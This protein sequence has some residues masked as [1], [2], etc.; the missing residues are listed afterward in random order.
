MRAERIRTDRFDLEPLRVEHAAEMAPLLADEALHR[1]TGGRPDSPAELRARYARQVVGRSPDGT[2]SWL[3]WVIRDRATA[4]PLGSVQATVQAEAAAP[5]ALVAWVVGTEHQGQGVA[6]EAAAAMVDWLR[7]RGV[8]HV[9][10]YVAP[11]A[12]RLDGRRPRDR[13]GAHGPG[14]GRRGRVAQWLNR[15][16]DG[17]VV[18][19][20]A[21][22]ACL[23]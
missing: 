20:W 14:R 21:A 8:E 6:R 3:N 23:R 13:P 1:F 15:A 11:G 10:A 16:P 18:A 19:L 5:V 12:R 22:G 2:E 17:V 4:R 9:A 7:Q